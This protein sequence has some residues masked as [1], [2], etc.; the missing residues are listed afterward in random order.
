MDFYPTWPSHSSL[1]FHM[2]HLSS[3]S[4][5][6]DTERAVSQWDMSQQTE[7]GQCTVTHWA[8]AGLFCRGTHESWRGGREREDSRLPVDGWILGLGTLCMGVLHDDAWQRLSRASTSAPCF[9]FEKRPGSNVAKVIFGCVA[10]CGWTF[11]WVICYCQ[12]WALKGR[13]SGVCGRRT[14]GTHVRL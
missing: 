10:C 9:W 2:V 12:A 4:F 5:I 14:P 7:A 1:E 6:H 13:V 11:S 8:G 3:S